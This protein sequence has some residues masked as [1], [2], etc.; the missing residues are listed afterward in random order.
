MSNRKHIQNP[1]TGSTPYL[2][3]ENIL[4]TPKNTENVLPVS[5]DNSSTKLENYIDEKYD[6]LAIKNLKGKNIKLG[7]TTILSQQSRGWNKY[8]INEKLE[9]TNRASSKRNI[10]FTQR[11]ERK[12]YFIENDHSF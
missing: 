5:A 10:F 9:R 7:Q 2:P 1:L 6:H 8:R 4:N 3:S 11:I 12:K